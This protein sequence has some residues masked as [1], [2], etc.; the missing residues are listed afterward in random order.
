[1]PGSEVAECARILKGKRRTL[2]WGH[3]LYQAAIQRV[4]PLV[5][6]NLNH[7][8][9]LYNDNQHLDSVPSSITRLLLSG[10]IGN[11]IRNER[12]LDEFGRVLTSVSQQFQVVV[13]KGGVLLEG[14]YG[15]LGIRFMV[16]LDILVSKKDVPGVTKALSDLG[17]V[18]GRVIEN[19]QRIHSFDR[20]TRA[21]WAIH[22]NNL[23]PFVRLDEHLM[24]RSY[25]VDVCL[26][27]FLPNSGFDIPVDDL[28]R[29]SQV[30][31]VAG[32]QCWVLSPEDMLL[33]LCAHTFKEA[34]TA[35]W[36]QINSDLNLIKFCDIAEYV[37]RNYTT[38]DW[39][40]FTSRVNTF[41][42][43]K[44]VFYS[45]FFT[46][47][48]YPDV[49]PLA[50]INEVRPSDVAYLDHYAVTSDGGHE[51]W[52]QGFLNRLFDDSRLRTKAF[53]DVPHP[54]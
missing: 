21:Y 11:R 31:D 30:V 26:N 3:F 36:T 9:L 13:R 8:G 51:V 29:R 19:G 15:D 54:L 42:L 37:R 25:N 2:D 45:M 6:R 47:L 27:L 41:D 24:V 4:L 34:T 7:H 12:L 5:A 10:Y 20:R 28:L 43:Q 46:D 33:D 14:L 1:M 22:S 44:P 39:K 53:E 50:V 38:I 23:L 48:L 40:L 52:G 32:A 18:Q 16:D 49:L 35:W 17:Y